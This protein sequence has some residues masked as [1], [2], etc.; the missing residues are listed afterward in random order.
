[1]KL[2]REVGGAAL[3]LALFAGAGC[4]YHVSGK[5]DLLPHDIRTIAVPAFANRTTRYQLTDEIPQ[6]IAR[7][8]LARTRYAVVADAK[9]A[10]AVLRGAIDNIVSY[11]VV[12]DQTTGRATAVEILV[13]MQVHLYNRA[14]KELYARQSMQLRE[15]YEISVNPKLYFDESPAALT[16]LSGEAA[17]MIVS[18]VLENF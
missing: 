15:Q 10:D 13:T 16:R 4:G 1:M 3:L 7:E 8:F 2:R 18:G 5:A 9:D 6:A 17:R 12:F 11:P 14:G